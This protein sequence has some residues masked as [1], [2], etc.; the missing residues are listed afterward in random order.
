LRSK[1]V[2]TEP[3]DSRLRFDGRVAVITG[4]GRGLGREFA[5]LLARR[6]SAVVVNDIGRSRDH[7]RYGA[8]ADTSTDVAQQVV[9]EIK[10]SGGSAAANTADV[11]DPA[12]A[13][14]IVTTAVDAFGRIDILINNAGI[15]PY[16]SL[17]EL[18]PE[19]FM[20]T[21]AVHVGGAFHVSRAAWPHFRRNG[22]GRIVNVCSSVGIV[23]GADNYA[24]YGSAKGG[25][26]GLTRVS[27]Q[28][29]AHHG[30]LVNGLLPNAAT[31]GR[32]SVTQP[33]RS[34]GVDDEQSAELVAHA[35][36]WLAHDQCSASGEFFAV[37]S[38]SMREIF[39]S[40]AEGFQARRP[41]E[42]SLELIQENW[43][44]IRDRRPA[45]SPTDANQYN[46]YRQAVFYRVTGSL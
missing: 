17:E 6:G 14:S 18:T 38:G 33:L 4:A 2:T 37:K 30:I 32:A 12:A 21:L 25:L 41:G 28:E 40:V 34:T 5:L 29:G 3:R 11:S 24:A 35:A 31:R 26:M 23:Y 8:P 36:A 13:E 10:A 19:Q 1:Q 45:L 7:E 46:D 39:V 44:T 42:F 22:Y 27:A 9:D 20:A 16:A 43:S 15:L